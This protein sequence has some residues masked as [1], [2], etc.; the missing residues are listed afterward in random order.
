M[1][2]LVEVPNIRFDDIGGLEETT[3]NLHEMI[4]CPVV[5]CHVL[6]LH[7]HEMIMCPVVACEVLLLHDRVPV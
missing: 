7:D 5:A 4:M 2:K 6:L 1:H 3:R